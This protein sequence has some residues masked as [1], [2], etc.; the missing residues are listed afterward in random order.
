MK[1][2]PVRDILKELISFDT[3]NPPGNEVSC[4]R[5]IAGLLDSRGFDIKLVS[6]SESRASL[7]ASCKKGR[8][9]KKVVLNG[10]IDVV[11][12]GDGWLTPPFTAVEKDGRIY[13]RGASDMKGGVAAMMAAAINLVRSP[14]NGEVMLNLVADEE[15]FNTGTLE[16]LPYTK[17]ADYVLIGEPTM[18]EAHITHRGILRFLITFA[19]RSCHSGLPRQGLNAIE[20]AAFGIL[21]LREYARALAGVTH[22]LLPSPTFVVSVIQGGEKDNMVPGSCFI[23]AD[24]R[25]LPGETEESAEEE[26]RKVLDTVKSDHAGFDYTLERYYYLSPGEVSEDAEITRFAGRVYRDC[27]G[28]DCRVT[29]FPASCEQSL[30]T[31]RGIPALIIGPGSIGQAHTRDEFIDLAQLDKA[32]RY[33]GEFLKQALA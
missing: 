14:F 12:P 7:A 28:E 11:P 23:R 26:V 22:P 13:G 10:H 18:M 20:N 33:Y 4:A 27:F 31:C 8:G 32:V 5:W 24:R 1:S 21:A 30:F 25:A 16:T 2:P 15:V 19:G 6:H 17:D 9:G 29:C 3:S